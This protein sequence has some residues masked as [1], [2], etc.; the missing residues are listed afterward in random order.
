MQPSLEVNPAPAAVRR[1]T[2][3]EGLFGTTQTD[4]LKQKSVRGGLAAVMAQG[5]TFAFQMGSTMVL[6]RLLSPEDFG[7]QGM[8]LAMTGILSL[9]RD[10]GLGLATIQQDVLTHEQTS[11]LFW[12]NV[13]LGSLLMLSAGAMAPLLVAFYKE[14][15]LLAMTIASSVAFLFNSLA[16]QHFALLNRA[17]RFGTIAKINVIAAAVSVAVGV[18]MAARGWGYWALVGMAISSPLVTGA[19]AWIAM[20]WL[21]GRP[22][23]NSGVRS[24]LHMGGT[25]TVNSVVVYLA[26]NLEK[27]LLGRFWG[28]D[29]L[30]IY[31]RGYQL[32]TLPLQQLNGSIGSVAFPALSRIQNDSE[33]L[34]RSFLK[35][36]SVLLSLAVPV[37]L[38]CALFADEVVGVVLGPK[39]SGAATVLR[40]LT[41]TILTLA[42]IN[43]FGWFLQAIGRAA[44][45]L[46]IA[47]LIAPMMILGIGAGLRYG[48][49]GVAIGY[50]TAMVFLIVPVVTWAKRDT[51]ITTRDYWDSVKQPLAAGAIAGA[52]GWLLKLAAGNTL[53]P[54]VLLALGLAATLGVYAWML[55]VVM[56]QRHLYADLLRQVFRREER[57]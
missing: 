38:A 36:Y 52:A 4:K 55:L 47:L 20:P 51:G 43:P 40:L 39:W 27:I 57:A 26:F 12:V 41:P 1:N 23:R 9:F 54:V 29:A 18:G 5:A 11:T 35:G 25:I 22:R 42:L 34:C 49:P 45:S 13:A 8:V 31:G 32:A 15:R 28:A 53:M 6:A 46:H 37:M 17:M 30:G 48:P 33:R 7:L 3:P 50:S 56:G 19:A 14:P 2:L 21:P 16:V 24:M 10:A 44:R